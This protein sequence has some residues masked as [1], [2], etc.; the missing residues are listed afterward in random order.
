V[1]ILRAMA[2][3]RG[4]R[5]SLLALGYAGWGPGQLDAELQANGWLTVG[6]DESLLFDEGLDDKWDRAIKKLGIDPAMLSVEAGRA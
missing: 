2:N 1:D 3:R 6:A 4:P 5:Q